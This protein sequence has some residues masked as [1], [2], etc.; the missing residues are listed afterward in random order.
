MIIDT[1]LWNISN[2]E[3]LE[4]AASTVYEPA[5]DTF[6]MLD[7]LQLDL[8]HIVIDRLTCQN[9]AVADPCLKRGLLLV[10]ELG[11]GAGLLTAAVGK[12]LHSCE[13]VGVHCLA[14]DVNPAACHATAQTC[15]LNGVQVDVIHGDLLTWMRHFEPT[16][17]ISD[18]SNVYGPID[19][20]LFNPPYVRGPDGEP[21]LSPTTTKIDQKDQ[22]AQDQLL[23]IM[24]DAAWLG[25]GPDGVDVLKRALHQAA[26][27]LSEQGVFYALMID[28]NY[29]ALVRDEMEAR[30]KWTTNNDII[31]KKTSADDVILTTFG[32]NSTNRPLACHKILSRHVPGERLAVYRIYRPHI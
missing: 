3:G 21:A 12:A 28:Y 32:S 29:R 18:H 16:N 25:G 4:T 11:C 13:S 5:E 17:A 22:V 14:V 6:L 24:A 8:E 9:K 15:Q 27:L 19:I 7:A 20:L 1:P 31:Y 26:D 10:V 23:S 2:E 30:Q